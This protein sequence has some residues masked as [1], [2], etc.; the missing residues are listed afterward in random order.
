LITEQRKT[1][2]DEQID[3]V[4]TS[5]SILLKERTFK[6]SRFGTQIKKPVYNWTGNSNMRV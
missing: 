6:N 2:K 4:K 5:W 1:L 3:V